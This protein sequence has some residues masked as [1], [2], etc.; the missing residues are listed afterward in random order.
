VDMRDLIASPPAVV[1]VIDPPVQ[2][3]DAGYAFT[4][5]ATLCFR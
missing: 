4:V 5:D 3:G 1:T 2:L